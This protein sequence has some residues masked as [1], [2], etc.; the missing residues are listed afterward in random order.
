MADHLK[1]VSGNESSLLDPVGV[2][3]DEAGDEVVGAEVA[4]VEEE[5]SNLGKGEVGPDSRWV[6]CLVLNEKMH[7]VGRRHRTRERKTRRRREGGFEPTL[8]RPFLTPKSFLSCE[9]DVM[10]TER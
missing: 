5:I 4:E 9:I 2:S 3:V 8:C 6:G 1:T 10:M 7:E